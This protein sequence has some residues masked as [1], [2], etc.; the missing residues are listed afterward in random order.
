LEYLQAYTGLAG[1]QPLVYTYPYWAAAVNFSKDIAACDLWIASYE[2]QPQIPA[3]WTD[4]VLWQNSGGGA[5][6]LPSGSPCD[7]NYAKDLSLWGK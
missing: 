4:W 5:Y 2:P 1:K 7:T 3:P 6:H